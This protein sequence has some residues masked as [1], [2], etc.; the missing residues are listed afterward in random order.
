M[1]SRTWE[2]TDIKNWQKLE[3]TLK[4]M[5]ILSKNAKIRDI[6]MLKTIP[7]LLETMQCPINKLQKRLPGPW[8]WKNLK[9]TKIFKN[10]KKMRILSNKNR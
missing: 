4:K 7:L 10:L 1:S 8:S 3:E 9:I 2:Y 5:Q 6:K